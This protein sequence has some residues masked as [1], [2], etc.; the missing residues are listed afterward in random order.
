[1]A[2]RI[3]TAYY[4]V[5]RDT[6]A[7]P[8]NFNSWSTDTFGNQHAWAKSGYGLI[9]KHVDVR[10]EHTESIRNAAARSTVLLKN[11]NRA[12]P[13]TGKEKFVTV[14]GSDAVVNPYGPNGCNDRGCDLGTLAMG[15]GSGSV[16]FPYL[17][18]PFIALQNEVT[19]NGGVIQSVSDDY[20]YN[21]ATALA[22]QAQQVGG[23]AI[24]FVNA[25]SGEGYINVDGNIG[26][27]KN[28]TL[29]HDGETLVS[30]VASANN[31]TIVI[32]HSVGPVLVPFKNNTNVTAILWAGLPGEQSG[33]AIV[34]IL[35]GRENPAARLPFTI[36]SS[37]EEYGADILYQGNNG[38]DAPQQ[39]FPE[40]IFIDYRAFDKA[41]ITPVYEF[42]Y[43]LSYTTFEYSNLRISKRN[44]G[45]YTPT[46]GT[47]K[48][49]KAYSNSTSKNPKDYQFPANFTRV[50]G[51]IYPW[52]ES[53]DGRV[54][55]HGQ[56]YGEPS[57]LPPHAT[58]GSAQ[59][60]IAAGG[61]PGGNPKLW[62]VL[63]T[64]TATVTNTGR[65]RGD[66]VAQV[67]VSLGGPNDAKVALRGF[68]RLS[69]GPGQA[70]TVKV[71][72]TRRDVSNWDSKRQDWFVSNF[73]KTVFVGSSSRKLPLSGKL[74]F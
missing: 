19:S 6:K 16:N 3:M 47:T 17:I 74:V 52:L 2:T 67:Y 8:L 43:G 32:I 50:K 29:W 69:I 70:S 31:N 26:D 64:V 60:R 22:R 40:G 34:D 38:A 10:G 49:A 33:N 57:D 65:V 36:G 35:Y 54:A 68:D 62:D 46:T 48:P 4:L 11:T 9:N 28:L 66:E 15:W 71:D 55:S 73:T 42:G 44:V 37:R 39:A 61:G 1:M 14:F 56:V 51:Y 30:K 59:P 45:P 27:R 72:I 53:T 24:V 12:L 21:Q 7:V 23:P 20:A 5:G 18:T 58:D 13:L 63:F 25:D 41:E